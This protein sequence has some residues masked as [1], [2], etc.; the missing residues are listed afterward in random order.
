MRK[1]L[2]RVACVSALAALGT[3]S[4]QADVLYATSGPISPSLLTIDPLT[5]GA[6]SSMPITGEESLFGGLCDD[7]TNLF[8]LDGYNDNNSDRTFRIDPATG[9]GTVVGDTT[10]NWNFRCTEVLRT[11]G[12]LYAS[13]DNALYTLSK[14]TGAAT[15]VANLSSPNLD[16]L[17]AL[18]IS[19]NGTAYVSD[20]GNTS[21]FRLD[22]TSGA[23]TFFGDAALGTWFSDL[24]FDSSG[25]LWGTKQGGGLYTIDTNTGAATFVSFA[26]D[27]AGISWRWSCIPLVYC[28]AKINSL[29]CTPSISAIGLPSATSGSGFTVSASNVINNKPGLLIYTNNGPAAV[30]FLGGTRCINTPI[31]RSIPLSSAGNPPPNDCSGVYSIDMN[32]F[33]VGALGGLPAAYLQAPGTQVNCQAWGRDN[34]FP[35]PNNSTLSDGLAYSICP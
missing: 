11:T 10:F 15:L 7:G 4:A 16:Q 12:V 1:S 28:T 24:S 18:A 33:A 27:L 9:T 30:P 5:G 23:L 25:T 31:R 22:L 29:G 35:V 8:S 32:A 19:P 21:V 34:G 2:I 3:S 20:I 14:V 26:G 13:R 6:L 17:T